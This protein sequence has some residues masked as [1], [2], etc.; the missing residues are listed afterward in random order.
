MVDNEL[1][2]I[3]V[4]LRVR[5]PLEPLGEL[6]ETVAVRKLTD[7]SVVLVG[8]RSS[9]GD[10]DATPTTPT[11]SRY[12]TPRRAT[13]DSSFVSVGSSAPACAPVMQFDFNGVFGPDD[14][15]QD[16]FDNVVGNLVDDVL[17]GNNAA[18]ICYG[19]TGSG[20]THTMLGR[21]AGD[22]PPIPSRGD[23]FVA[24][25]SE[26]GILPRLVS[27]L[28]QHKEL[29]RKATTRRAL[30]LQSLNLYGVEIYQD[31]VRD[32]LPASKPPIKMRDNSSLEEILRECSSKRIDDCD[33]IRRFYDSV[34]AHR[35]VCSHKLNEQSSRSH[36]VFF[37]EIKQ[38]VSRQAANYK[39]ELVE[40]RCVTSF[41]ALVDLAG[42]ERV[43][44][45]QV[46]G[47]A[48]QE[49]QA[50][51][52]SL[53]SLASVVHALYHRQPHVPYRDS[54]LTRIL[55][56]CFEQ[57]F[58]SVIVHTPPGARH[59]SESL[60]TLRFADRLKAIRT[61]FN[62]ARQTA[63]QTASDMR[64]EELYQQRA[65]T[66]CELHAELRI[67]NALTGHLIRR[68]ARKKSAVGADV[69]PLGLFNS[70]EEEALRKQAFEQLRDARV[71]EALRPGILRVAA[72]EAALVR[73]HDD[74]CESSPNSKKNEAP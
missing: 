9:T 62:A 5:P 27:L 31:E 17:D 8:P 68:L 30:V 49:A 20:K 28:L 36:A 54:R 19:P 43:K 6:F 73:L 59:H 65:H 69:S 22:G 26:I 45:T 64:L 46:D 37:L 42:S 12:N 14:T 66:A 34:S 1:E 74:T 29:Y 57:G 38:A 23:N 55:R 3:K 72:V 11:D 10:F 63:L 60:V 51:N 13:A 67:A 70:K 33:Q 56:P 15:Q 32:L 52:K 4:Y 48:L 18:V 25:N 7:T 2:S 71:A 41:L 16:L 24:S 21:L 47:I 39:S 53:S 40:G 44:K 50:I 35:V 58:L 61:S